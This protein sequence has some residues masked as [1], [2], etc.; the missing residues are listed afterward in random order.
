MTREDREMRKERQ[1]AALERL[2]R[3][4]SQAE[5]VRK[6]KIPRSTLSRA[7]DRSK[8]GLLSDSTRMQL[9]RSLGRQCKSEEE[10]REWV[11]QAGW[12]MG[13]EEWREALAHIS[14]GEGILHGVPRMLGVQMVGRVE[15]M[16]RLQDWLLDS[17]GT[18]ERT[19]VIQGVGGVGKTTLAVHAVRKPEVWEWY[20]GG[21]YWVRMEE[22]EEADA[23]RELA[24][25]VAGAE[26]LRGRD[27]WE[28]VTEDLQG[29]WV[30][31]VLDGVGEPVDLDRWGDILP[32]RG[33][34]LVTSRVAG[35]EG[36]R[37]RSRVMKVEG[38]G[39]AEALELLAQD[40]TVDVGEAELAWVVRELEGLPLALYIGN[41][42]GQDEGG[43]GGFVS[44]V[45]TAGLAPLHM[46]KQK[47]KSVRVTFWLSYR[48]LDEWDQ[49]LFWGLGVFPPWFE[50]KRVA[51]VLGL[52]EGAVRR[53]L[54]RME[55]VGLVENVGFGEYQVH[56]LVHRY[57]IELSLGDERLQEWQERFA[58]HYLEVARDV[59]AAQDWEMLGRHLEEIAQGAI[60]A[61]GLRHRDMVKAYVRSMGT[62][63]SSATESGLADWLEWIKEE[64][65]EEEQLDE[66]LR[67]TR[68]CLNMR[69]AEDALGLVRELGNAF[70]EVGRE[71]EWVQATLI[72]GEALLALGRAAEAAEGL[73]DPTMWER[74]A[75]LDD[76]DDL[77]FQVWALSER[78]R[79]A[80]NAET[81]EVDAQAE[82]VRARWVAGQASQERAR[83]RLVRA[84]PLSDDPQEAIRALEARMELAEEVEERDMWLVDALMRGFLRA[85]QGKVEPAEVALREV[86][87][88][89]AEMDDARFH[90]WVSLLEAHVAWAAGQDEAGAQAYQAA[91][92][93]LAEVFGETVFWDVDR[94]GVEGQTAAERAVEVWH[95]VLQTDDPFQHVEAVCRAYPVFVWLGEELPEDDE[96][97]KRQYQ[98]MREELIWT[99]VELPDWEWFAEEDDDASGGVDER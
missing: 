46:W 12:E 24:L 2:F 35:L 37:I 87:Q 91:A 49:A 19:L 86:D 90:P 69:R 58:A 72:E 67:A 74:V 1:V 77:L 73:E 30:L 56:N 99:G 32:K 85:R 95:R 16:S 41:C 38:L 93:E 78:V 57:A 79:A 71:R 11:G 61:C 75:S 22:R 47:D 63:L 34:L 29:K 8:P 60:Y 26:A 59:D 48:R 80:L 55:Q 52:G 62:Y 31:V 92:A 7:L 65:N 42:V 9:A 81:S 53:G 88:R 68:S 97:R 10:L 21:V 89:E 33:R 14:G 36:P 4:Q 82:T 40:V 98:A 43:L 76:G 17:S 28:L 96:E 64:V 27:P 50:S 25:K 18:T 83:L 5:V 66:M 15:E 44:E 6:M 51:A 70:G 3:K 23:I 45:R 39:Q 84:T 13:K 94:D 20:P 54:R